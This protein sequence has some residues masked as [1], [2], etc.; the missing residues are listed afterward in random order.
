M[1]NFSIWIFLD[2]TLVLPGLPKTCILL[3]IEGGENGAETI[4][5]YNMDD[6]DMVAGDS[7]YLLS[8][9]DYS[10]DPD[11][12]LVDSEARV[13]L[14]SSG[15]PTTMEVPTIEPE[16]YSRWIHLYLKS[17]EVA[18]CS[19]QVVGDRVP[20]WSFWCLFLCQT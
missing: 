4:T 12:Q 6:Y 20:G 17:Q 10:A 18:A 1:Q 8:V 14:Y 9:H 5:W 16:E 15:S 2:K 3:L 19:L 7:L 13:A 11:H